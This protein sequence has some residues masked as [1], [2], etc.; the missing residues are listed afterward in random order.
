MDAGG[1]EVTFKN[2]ASLIKLERVRAL[3]KQSPMTL[4]QLAQAADCTHRSLYRYLEA[5]DAEIHIAEWGRIGNNYPVP[6]FA[7]GPGDDAHRPQPKK[8]LSGKAKRKAIARQATDQERDMIAEAKAKAAQIRPY[9]DPW[10]E[11]MYGK[12]A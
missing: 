8:K 3:L 7:Y 9:R 1:D 6:V 4:P 2:K 10:I 12:A 5:L 11:A